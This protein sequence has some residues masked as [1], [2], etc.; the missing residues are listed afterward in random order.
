M[1]WVPSAS[2]SRP[3]SVST[4]ATPCSFSSSP[5]GSSSGTN[6]LPNVARSWSSVRWKS[7]RGLSSLLTNTRRGMPSA[8]H[9]RHAASV[10]T[11]TPS[12]ALTTSTAR[13]A[14]ARAALDLA[15]EVG[16]AG[17]VEEV[18]LVRRRLAGGR[19]GR[20][21]LERG[22]GQGDRHLA[23]DL[24][25]LGVTDGGA[26]V[27]A[28]R[29]VGARRPGRAAP[30]RARSCR[31]RCGRRGRRFVCGRSSERSIGFPLG[32]GPN[33]SGLAT[34]CESREPGLDEAGLVR[35]HD[36]LHPIRAPSLASTRPT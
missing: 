10:P 1:W 9:R 11:S 12:T 4:S 22:D 13:S 6:P 14:T 17:S 16:V 33:R 24:L 5:R 30:R 25:R 21:P 29:L 20:L 26:L 35:H 34:A 8:A 7:A 3:S 28:P 23:L 27:G 2:Y 32:L 18:D 31:Y 19:V 15:G 36:R